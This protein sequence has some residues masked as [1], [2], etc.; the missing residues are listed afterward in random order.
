MQLQEAGTDLSRFAD[1]GRPIVVA[2]HPRSGTHLTIDFLRRQFAACD[3]RKLPGES[4]SALYLNLDQW[5]QK[6]SR[7]SL[8][9]QAALARL[10]RARRPIVKTHMLFAG[11]Q[12]YRASGEQV[13][14]DELP[15]EWRRWLAEQATWIY[16][17]RDGR[18][19]MASYH[20]FKQTHRPALRDV[21][22]PAF[23][24]QKVNG[25]RRAR[26]W[27]R[28]VEA[29]M[30]RS[31]VHVIRLEEI[32]GRPDEAVVRLAQAIE[33]EPRQRTPLVPRKAGTSALARLR[34]RLATRPESTAVLGRFDGR[35][36]ARWRESLDTAER[37]RFHYDAGDVLERLGY[38][39]GSDWCGDAELPDR[40]ALCL[41][42]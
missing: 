38:E 11:D 30:E 22:F 15:A 42:G 7:R 14:S 39:D 37:E 41:A 2:S 13:E 5:I 25:E 23:L 3:A 12:L 4:S 34:S 40:P 29:W 18:D 1:I 20:L 16:V 28:H 27:A 21:D 36:P 24:R 35:E 19:V 31:N 9:E 6:G 17:V 10:A 8:S 26:L 32:L 33:E